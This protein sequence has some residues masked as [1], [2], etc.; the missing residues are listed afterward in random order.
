MK[1]WSVKYGIVRILLTGVLLL[2][3]GTIA[4]QSF[5]GRVVYS[6]GSAELYRAGERLDQGQ[7]N[8]G[9]AIEARDLVVTQANGLVQIELTYPGGDAA[10]VTVQ[11]ESSFTFE[12]DDANG[13]EVEASVQYGSTAFQVDRSSRDDR[14]RVRT[15]TAAMG[16]RG[17]E[18]S[19][20][21]AVDGSVLVACSVGSVAVSGD[22]SREYR[23]EPGS[24]V[25]AIADGELRSESV[26]VDALDTFRTE[27]SD[28]REGIFR[29]GAPA[30]IRGYAR[31]YLQLEPQFR[32]AHRALA[33]QR[34]LLENSTSGES[35]LGSSMRAQ[36][37]ASPAAMEMR[38]L[39][40]RFEEVFSQ[41]VV[42][43]RYHADGV[44]RGSITDDLS[45]SE[46][47]RQFNSALIPH[48]SRLS[49][50]YYLLRLFSELQASSGPGGMPESSFPGGNRPF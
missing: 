35:S 14:F 4:A 11:P 32:E 21:I 22:E 18:F 10:M 49:D 27:W 1:L 26:A 23:A 17:T 19:V 31:R 6:E 42:L 13:G 37:E 44:G 34:R 43:S 15:R 36:T 39:L 8:P 3:A 12:V 9:T 30:F 2:S 5:S 41:L 38:A 24:V 48:R 40:P 29:R 46:F 47:F 7:L 16:V 33:E 25:E 45:S 20:D 50:T 28:V